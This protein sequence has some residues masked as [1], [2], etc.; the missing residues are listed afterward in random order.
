VNDSTFQEFYY[1]TAPFPDFCGFQYS[2]A[3]AYEAGVTRRDPSPVI[4]VDGLYYVWYSRSMTSVDGYSASIWYATS[5]DGY[6]WTEMGEALPKGA[7]GAFDEHAVFTPTILM[8]DG[9]YFLFYTAV[10]AP[11]TNDMGGSNCTPTAIG[12]AISDS[13]EGPWQRFSGNPVLVPR[14]SPEAFDSLRIDD[15]CLICRN[16]EYW[17]YYKGRQQNRSPHETKMG[18]AIASSPEGPYLKHAANPVLDS[19]HEVCVWP[20][21]SGV[22]CLVCDVGPQGNSLQYCEDGIHFNYMADTV[23][24]S[25]PG[26]F[27]ADGFVDGYG[28]GITWGIAMR[29]DAERPYLVRFDCELRSD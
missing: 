25:A 1:M 21:G 6:S 18:L 22:G 28:P 14:K 13:P 29:C 15:A 24:P 8:A 27:R 7:V 4:L 26:P 12:V 5:P 11:F 17:M 16:G 9:Q 20:H 2:D 10:P 19:G 3:I 23:P